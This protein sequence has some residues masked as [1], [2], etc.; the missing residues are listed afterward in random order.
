MPGSH[1]ANAAAQPMT[2]P[3]QRV[4]CPSKLIIQR[5]GPPLQLVMSLTIKSGSPADMKTCPAQSLQALQGLM[6]Q[7]TAVLVITH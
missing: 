4:E 6:Q 5:V 7:C 3:S 1:S 2:V